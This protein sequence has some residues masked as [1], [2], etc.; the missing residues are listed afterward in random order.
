MATLIRRLRRGDAA[1]EVVEMALVTPLLLLLVMGI[2]DFGFL[3]QRYLVIT[4]AAVEGARVAT[5]NG[6]G[7]ADAQARVTDYAEAG[8]IP[9]NA[10]TPVVEAAV[11]PGPSGTPWP[12][13]RVTVTHVYNLQFVAPIFALVGGPNAANV[14]LTARST[15]RRQVA[16][17]L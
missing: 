1:A 13:V 3:F 12:A 7:L 8:G 6:Y 9:P 4:N 14:T 17:G 5:M 16:A 15:M 2:V 11:L 10:V